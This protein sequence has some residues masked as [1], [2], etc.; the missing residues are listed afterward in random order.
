MKYD[1]QCQFIFLRIILLHK[2]KTIELLRRGVCFFLKKKK[3]N[4]VAKFY[5]LTCKMQKINNLTMKFSR[6]NNISVILWWSGFIGGAYSAKTSV[7]SY[8]GTLFS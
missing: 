5:R 4:Y 2:G 7:S 1:R 3:E 6:R 8:L